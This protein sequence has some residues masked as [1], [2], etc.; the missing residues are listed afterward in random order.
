M[1]KSKPKADVVSALDVIEAT[2]QQGGVSVYVVYGDDEFLKSEA[3]AALRHSLLAGDEEGFAVS[4]FA[5]DKVQLRDVRDALSAV[6]LFGS[7]RRLVVVKDAD[8]FVSRYRSELEDYVAKPTRDAVLVLEVTT[9][10]SNTRLAKAVASVGQAIDCA[11][12]NERKLKPW[13]VRRAKERHELRLEAAAADALCERLPPEPG[14]LVQELA[15]LALLAGDHR[16][17]DEQLVRTHVGGWR[18]RTTWEM[19]D[20]AADGRAAESLS[21]LDRLLLAGEKPHALLPQLASTLR[22]FGVAVQLV[23]SAEADG[24]RLPL[25]DALAQAGVLPFKL[26]TA[27]QQLRQIGRERAKQLTRWLLAADLALKGHNSS[28]DR[29]RGELERLIVRLA[30]AGNQSPLRTTLAGRSG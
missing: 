6:S 13:L 12:P 11:A 25:R 10:P 5:G 14:I 4:E 1:S 30:A 15:K 3:I 27:E 2:Q 23:E 8:A 26:A 29:A 21:Q 20:L 16:V 9:W 24:R 22:R 28:D 19:I 18:T 7:G 17:I